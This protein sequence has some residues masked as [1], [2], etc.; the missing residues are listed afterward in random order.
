MDQTISERAGLI[1]LARRVI[2]WWAILGGLLL[3]AAV[4]LNVYSVLGG[5][6]WQPFP[7]EIELNEIAVAVAVF[8]FLPYCQLVGAN[9]S[10]DIFTS[11]AGPRWVAGF[12]FLGSLV[13]LVFCLTLMRQMYL[14]MLDQRE[15]NYITAVLQVPIWL[16]Y[17]PCVLSLA[18]LSVASLITL[19]ENGSKTV[20]A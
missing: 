19:V 1:G 18:L 14:G 13:A 16:G 15:Y 8:A 7:G 12:A 9:V 11:R 4:A 10:A 17:L 20:K 3:V 2:T 5:V 6:F